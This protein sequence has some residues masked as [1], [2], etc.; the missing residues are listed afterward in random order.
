MF[1]AL[2]PG[3]RIAIVD[4]IPNDS[5]TGPMFPLIFALNMLANT[6]SGD[7]YSLAEYRQWLTE[8]GFA[9]VSTFDIGSHS[10]LIV[11]HK[12]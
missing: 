3:G 1:R 10:P 6:E 7:T 5:R 8:A 9:R 11:G 2:R 4:M 12:R